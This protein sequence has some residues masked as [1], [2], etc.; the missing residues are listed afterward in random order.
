MIDAIIRRR[1]EQGLTDISALYAVLR[2]K[3]FPVAIPN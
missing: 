1:A 2:R 3:K